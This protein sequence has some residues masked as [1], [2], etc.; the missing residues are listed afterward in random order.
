[1]DE[2][3][4]TTHKF[5]IKEYVEWVNDATVRTRTV[6]IILVIATVLI[7]IG[8]YNS[9]QWSWARDRIKRVFDTGDTSIYTLMDAENHPKFKSD[10]FFI[11]SDFTDFRSLAFKLVDNQDDALSRYIFDRLPQSRAPLVKYV[12]DYKAKPPGVEKPAPSVI[13]VAQ[14]AKDFN[15]FLKDRN[16]YAPERFENIKL[17]KETRA[18]LEFTPGG[19]DLMR[20]N[21]LLL[22]DYFPDEIARSRDISPADDYRKELQRQMVFH[23]I[24]NIRYI[25]VPFFG[26]SFDVNDLG[27][28]GGLGLLIILMMYRYSLSREIKN[29]RYAFAT[30]RLQAREE[31]NPEIL[32]KFYHALAMKQVFT[33]PEMK[34]LKRNKKLAVSS[35]IV[36]L[37]PAI[38][39]SA[40]VFY[41]WWSVIRRGLYKYN[42]ASFTLWLELFWLPPVWILAVR[43]A[44]RIVH[45]DQIW[46][47][48][49]RRLVREKSKP[50][51]NRTFRK[52]R[53]LKY[54]FFWLIFPGN[55]IAV[56]GE[57]SLIPESK[58]ENQ[59][60]DESPEN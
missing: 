9:L 14:V 7:A 1:M 59:A 31:K 15:S 46:R 8:F 47:V 52:L 44:G 19:S 18:F 30:A 39:F 29:L 45:L 41:D 12:E 50:R 34:T 16:L 25:K 6:A 23:Y 21:R 48:Y 58:E 13:L 4:K 2:D 38:I 40:G 51:K 54:K 53:T 35:V 11:P 10:S 42:E 37:L 56:T 60:E 33:V 27:T 3:T 17:K 57:T 20:F 55:I 26:I 43:C 22:E 32:D 49:W 36:P 28:I 24:D 5:N